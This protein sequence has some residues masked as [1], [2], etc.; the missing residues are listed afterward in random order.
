MDY[1]KMAGLANE[2]EPNLMEFYK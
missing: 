1:K 2:V